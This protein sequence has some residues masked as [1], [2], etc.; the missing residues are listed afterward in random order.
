[1]EVVVEQCKTARIRMGSQQGSIMTES[2][3]FKKLTELAKDL[4]GSAGKLNA[5]IDRI[6]AIPKDRSLEDLAA[7][8]GSIARG[9]ALMSQA[10]A[11]KSPHVGKESK[12]A[13]VRGCQWRLVMAMAGFEIIVKG[14]FQS[15]RKLKPAHINRIADIGN[16]A[17][18]APLKP[19]KIQP[20]Q[21]EKWLK[22]KSVFRFLDVNEFDEGVLQSWLIE[23]KEIGG[24][25][26]QLNLIR[27]LRNCTVHAALSAH[28]CKQ[29]G[30]K[31]ALDHLPET[32]AKVWLS[33]L[34]VLCSE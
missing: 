3:N 23:R 30:L 26:D 29:F 34:L 10:L 21:V 25:A 27:T 11:W 31:P 15:S 8:Y 20:K 18:I 28:K 32:V 12:S 24:L 1:M 2:L 9:R 13:V 14:L 4:P 19:P 17:D 6:T 16:G 22:D 33:I 7:I 5:A